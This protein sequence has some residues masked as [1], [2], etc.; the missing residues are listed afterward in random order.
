MSDHLT[1]MATIQL[2]VVDDDL[3][4][5]SEVRRHWLGDRIETGSAYKEAIEASGQHMLDR[6]GGSTEGAATVDEDN[7][8]GG[9]NRTG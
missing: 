8:A 7:S 4:V 5:G 2:Q 3:R 6:P 1:A 9:T